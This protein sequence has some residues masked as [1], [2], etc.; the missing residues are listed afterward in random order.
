[1]RICEAIGTPALMNQMAEECCELAQAALK[2]RRTLENVNPS[3]IGEKTAWVRF[4]EEVADVMV[5]INELPIEEADAKSVVREM[6]MKK[7]RWK[8]RLGI[9]DEEK[10]DKPEEAKKD[11]KAEPGTEPED[12][13][14]GE[15][16]PEE[17]KA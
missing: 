8:N 2:Y 6:V 9:A 16:E 4:L 13:K 11:E 15:A 10:K 17:G 5:C 12:K 3:P 14:P 1:M 7:A